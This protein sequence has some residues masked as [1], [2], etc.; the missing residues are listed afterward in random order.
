[1]AQRWSI[2]WPIIV[3][4][5][6]FM[7][8]GTVYSTTV[9]LWEAPDEPAHFAYIA[10]LIKTCSMPVQEIGVLDAAHHPPLYYVIAALVSSVAD[11]EDHTGILRYNPEFEWAG[12]NTVKHN[13]GLHRT[14]ETFPYRGIALAAHLARCVSVA[15][16]AATVALTYTIARRIFPEHRK[17]KLALLA[18]GLVAFNPQFLFISS[19]VSIDGMATATCTFAL[20]LLVR[21]LANPSQWQAWAVTGIGCGLAVLAKSSSFTVGLTA[22]V[23]LFVCAIRRR[24]LSLLWRDGLALG[25][26]FLLISGWWFVRNW[27]LYGDPLGWQTFIKT[28]ETVL[29]DDPVRWYDIHRFFTV[30]FQSYWGRF[31]WMTIT[32]PDEIFRAIQVICGLGAAGWGAWLWRR[33]RFLVL[34]GR[35]GL[36]ALVVLPLLQEGFQFRSIFTFDGSWYQGRYLFPAIATLS[37]LLA[38]GLWH[39][40]TNHAAQ[41]GLAAVV[42]ASLLSLAIAVPLC[43]I[44]PQYPT[45]TLAKWRVW[46]LPY[47]SDATFGER[48]RL[49]GYE[50]NRPQL[51]DQPDVTVTFYWQAIKHPEL[52]YSVFV[53]MVDQSG[54]LIGQSD[55]GLGSDRDYPSS[56]WWAEDIVPSQHVL[57]LPVDRKKDVGEIRIGVYF[58]PSGERLPATEHGGFVGDFITLD[59]SVFGYPYNA[60]Q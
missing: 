19:S 53:H 28:W 48:I 9:P 41:T 21:A 10:H 8:L 46:T 6:V 18:A 12:L 1:M 5:A 27:V 52:S 35:L 59:P 47:H 32:M 45:P 55:V 34:S 7:I 22:C 15:S 51:P 39:L 30:Q 43:I 42:G 37:I 60:D 33:R 4:V 26:A 57:V 2:E 36:V 17:R 23:M 14:S 25:S 29:R 31:G 54:E 40:M 38:A 58:A 49:L 24:S 16:G 20:W 3:L 13:L 11:Y 44:R 56:A 50:V